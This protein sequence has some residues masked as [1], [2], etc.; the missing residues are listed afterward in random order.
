MLAVLIAAASALPP[1]PREALLDDAPTQVTV[2]RAQPRGEPLRGVAEYAAALAAFTLVNA[3]GSALLS[4]SRVTVAKGGSVSFNG[5]QPSLVCAGACFVLTPLA[6]ALT[7]WLIGKGSD[8]WDP[9][10]GWAT[11]G[12]YGTSLAAVGAGLGLAAMNVDRGAA[13]AANTALYLAVPLGTVLV[14]N[15]TKSP[16]P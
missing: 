12:A 5:S 15:A 8:E 1:A 14:Q 3:G 2:A 13:V 16:R 11:L 4:D 10:L 7:S 9:S 6:A